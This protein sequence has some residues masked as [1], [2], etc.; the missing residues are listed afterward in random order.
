MPDGVG[1]DRLA[2]LESELV[3]ERESGRVA[4]L[5]EVVVH[6]FGV[7]QGARFPGVVAVSLAQLRVLVSSRSG[8]AIW[9]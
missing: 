4:A 6:E 3:Q 9:F 1:E 8:P 2:L 7:L 5:L